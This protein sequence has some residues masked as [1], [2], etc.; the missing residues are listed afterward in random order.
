MLTALPLLFA[1]VGVALAADF[2]VIVNGT[3]SHS[4]P[5]TLCTCYVCFFDR[6]SLIYASM[7]DGFMFEVNS[8]CNFFE[9]YGI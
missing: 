7:I 4:I 6:R 8:I 3:A 2:Q 9:I 5:S 1:V